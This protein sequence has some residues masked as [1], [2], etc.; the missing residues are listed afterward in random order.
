[1]IDV[2]NKTRIITDFR[3]YYIKKTKVQTDKD[4]LIQFQRIVS[5]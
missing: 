3:K 4:L 1:L 2:R 5:V